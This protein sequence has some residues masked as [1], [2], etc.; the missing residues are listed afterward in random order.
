MANDEEDLHHRKTIIWH[1]RIVPSFQS[2]GTGNHFAYYLFDSSPGRCSIWNLS[3]HLDC[4]AGVVLEGIDRH[5]G[6]Y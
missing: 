4:K 3:R 6:F 5:L 1:D 2:M